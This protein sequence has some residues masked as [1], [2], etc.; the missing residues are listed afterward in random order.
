MSY[1]VIARWRARAGKLQEVE[2]A[3]RALAPAVR[4]E[5]GNVQFIVHRLVENPN[6]FLLYET[7]VTEEAFLEH[8]RTPHFVKYV[9]ETAAP[10]LEH[11]VIEKFAKESY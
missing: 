10:L 8:R 7:Y 9:Q 11:R 1:H 5:P 2:A 3:L 6:E 4:N